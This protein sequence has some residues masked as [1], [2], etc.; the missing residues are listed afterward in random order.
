MALTSLVYFSQRFISPL[1]LLFL[2]LSGAMAARVYTWALG[3][4][5]G[6]KF[7]LDGKAGLT[8]H[9]RS[10]SRGENSDILLDEAL[11]QIQQPRLVVDGENG[12]LLV[13]RHGESRQPL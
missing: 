10:S 12:N 4:G 1:L 9:A 5:R 3:I 7:I 6:G 13:C 11:G 2:F 8:D